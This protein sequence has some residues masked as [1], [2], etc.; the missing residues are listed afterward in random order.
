MA[1]ARAIRAGAGLDGAVG[2]HEWALARANGA[3]DVQRLRRRRG[4]DAHLDR[5]R[6]AGAVQQLDA[7]EVGG[8]RAADLQVAQG[9]L[10]QNAGIVPVNQQLNS[11]LNLGIDSHAEAGD[12]I[13]NAVGR[14]LPYGQ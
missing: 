1:V 8:Q 3:V 4:A 10:L 9:I 7:V 12:K 2:G 6:A 13:G 5:D 11:M 14:K